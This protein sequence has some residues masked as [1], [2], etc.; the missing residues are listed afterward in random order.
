MIE[1]NTKWNENVKVFTDNIEEAALGQVIELAN[2]DLGKNAH[3]RIMPDVHSGKGCVIG[4]TMQIT[5]KVCPNLVGVDIACGVQLVSVFD[6]Y[7]YA[8]LDFASRWQELDAA[9]RK[10]VPSG[11]HHHNQETYSRLKLEKLRCWSR[12]SVKHQELALRSVGTLGGGNHFIEAYQDGKLAVHSG[13][14]NLGL[15]VATYY[16][17]LAVKR[18]EENAY[19]PLN[20]TNIPTSDRQAALA[21]H[22]QSRVKA[23]KH[24]AW[25]EGEDMEDYL[26]DMQIIN[27]YA[28][29][30]RT[31]I[32]N[33]IAK[34]MEGIISD[35]WDCVHN[36]IDSNRI[37]RKGSIAAKKGQFVL[38]PMNMR[39]GLI[40]GIG[41]GN[42]D[43]N[44]SAPHGAGRL[45]SRSAA[46][47]NFSLSDFQDTMRDVQSTTVGMDTI[48][49]APFAYK[50]MD[51]II[52]A[53]KETMELIKIFKPVYNF[54]AS[55]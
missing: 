3:I 55:E 43:W 37:L 49:E 13:S 29:A 41:L 2:S 10:Q 39:D 42:K 38:I 9:I 16:Q 32:L 53:T 31:A 36:Y 8:H 17:N 54:K 22:K 14:R 50:D 28:L 23:P 15:Q 34:A 40:I 1:L 45:Y 33:N 5:D 44:E 19:N 6:K 47:R 18:M 4:T 30:N 12:L 7:S 52:G 21:A 26:F 20:L 35:K 46:K 27:E 11:K 48:D 25:L 24:L 51:E